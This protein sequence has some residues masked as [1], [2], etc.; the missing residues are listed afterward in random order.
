M[1][2]QSTSYRS[3][4]FGDGISPKTSAVHSPFP[5]A[6]RPAQQRAEQILAVS[7][8]LGGAVTT[9]QVADVIIQAALPIF[10]AR[11]GLI[12]TLSDD[13]S[14]LECERIVGVPDAE[15]DLWRS[16]P[17]EA[18]LPLADA[19]RERRLVALI[20]SEAHDAAYP[21]LGEL[22]SRAAD[23]ALLAVPLLVGERCVGGIG[24]I[25]PPEYCE[26]DEQQTFLWTLAGQCALA[27]DRARLYDAERCARE[28]AQREVAERRLAER[29]LR[30]SEENLRLAIDG[31]RLGTF[32]CD[33]PLDRIVWNDTCKEHFFLPPDATVDFELFYSLLHPD[34]RGPTQIAIE[35]AMAEHVEYDVEYR[36]LGPNGQIRWINAVG[37]FYYDSQGTPV[38]FD[39]IT[40]D[41]SA[42]KASETELELRAEREHFLADLAERARRL[43]DPDE[44]IADAVRSVGEFLGVSRCVFADIDIEADICTIRPD[45]CADASVVSMSGTFPIS[46]FGGA[47]VAAYVAGRVIA[48]DEV[49]ADPDPGPT[50]N[51][52]AYEASGIRAHASVPVMHSS[53]LVS[54]IGVHSTTPRHWTSEEIELLQT[55][56][57]RTWLTVEVARQQRA[58][59]RESEERREAHGRTERILESITDAF[60]ALDAEFCFSYVNRQSEALWGRAREEMLGRHFLDVFPEATGSLPF[61]QHERALKERVPLHYETISP[62]IGSWV[63][64]SIYPTADGGLSVFF[65]DIRER[66]ALEAERAALAERERNIAQQLQ[67]ALQPALP[68][69]I[70]GLSV[71]KFTRPALEEAQIGG[72]FF[73]IFP[74]DTERYAVVIGDVSGK[75]LAAAQQ[76]ALVRN[77]LRTTLYLTQA[78]AQATASL[79]A[80]VTPHDL[81]V[82]FVTAFVGIYEAAT[83][84]VTY[85]SC[86]H[87]PGLVRRRDGTTEELGP[88]GPPLGIA[89]DAT[90]EQGLVTLETGDVLLLYTDGMSEAGP[91]RRELL[92]TAGLTR[93]LKSLPLSREMQS[94]AESLVAHV[95]DFAGGR[96]RDD[97]AV[98]LAR[99]E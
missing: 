86:G 79:N 34:D 55:V 39:G 98:L 28:E 57:E 97:V 77:S 88:T 1:P 96:F 5:S 81:L 60:Y 71:G 72:D 76:L 50:G 26:G 13:G 2:D 94:E 68:D 4:L 92:G 16:F 9:A 66:K 36:T 6:Q 29:A 14:L 99:R 3:S 23:G 10:Q 15:A 61:S 93:L 27:L 63:E 95:G 91:N 46:A 74:L 33:W 30:R 45:Y 43:T 90:Y 53:R 52:A 18:R 67:D 32:Y 22:R 12:A 78:P 20:T 84:V 7:T 47:V 37:R 64:V 87:E 49:R 59:A 40:L 42:R 58:L 24:L 41:T 48:V 51:I 70:Q 31:A 83:G 35:R 54:R 38:R 80:I 56:A 17:T 82:G 19:V 89:A 11:V 69:Q 65:R 8:A 21:G 44:V 25:C 85:A 73:D 62:I 75:G